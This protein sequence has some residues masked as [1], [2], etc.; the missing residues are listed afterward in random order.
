MRSLLDQ[1]LIHE[2]V[3]RVCSV[4]RPER[5]ILFGSAV[6]G[7]MTPDS[8]IDLL[9]LERQLEDSRAAAV[10]IRGALRG[11]GYPFDVLVMSSERFEESKNVIGGIAHPA[12]KYGEVIFEVA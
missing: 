8:D 10:V 1:S 3:R 9:V 2:I 7:P 4:G 6:S 12:D 5:I 11:L